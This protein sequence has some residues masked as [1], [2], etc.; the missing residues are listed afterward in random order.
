MGRLCDVAC[1]GADA[2]CNID[3]RGNLDCDAVTCLNGASCQIQCM[4]MAP[5]T[6]AMCTNTAGTMG[7]PQTCA[8]GVIV[9]NKECPP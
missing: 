4:G 2:E 5:C 7:A 3:C 8:R 9:C 1:T 6:F